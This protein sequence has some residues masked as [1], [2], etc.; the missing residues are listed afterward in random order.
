M[1][2]GLW[3]ALLKV[4]LFWVFFSLIFSARSS[5]PWW[6]GANLATLKSQSS[7]KRLLDGCLQS[8]SPQPFYL[9]FS[10]LQLLTTCLK[11]CSACGRGATWCQEAR[12]SPCWP[13][14]R[15]RKPCTTDA[16]WFMKKNEMD[17]FV[18]WTNWSHLETCKLSPSTQ[19]RFQHYF[20]QLLRVGI[21]A[22]PRGQQKPFR[23]PWS[24]SC[25]IARSEDFS[26]RLSIMSPAL[27]FHFHWPGSWWGA[28]SFPGSSVFPAQLVL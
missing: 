21:W 10:P 17:L 3:D 11:H 6:T 1:P 5:Y 2:G 20:C 24:W 7:D 9:L 12:P 8:P 19:T 4:L 14:Q 23:F 22:S 18:Q 16:V 26:K 25:C 15:G 27:V 13:C 28:T